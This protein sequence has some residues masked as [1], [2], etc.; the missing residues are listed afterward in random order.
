MSIY[1][2]QQNLFYMGWVVELSGDNRVLDELSKVLNLPELSIKKEDGSYYLESDIYNDNSAYKDVKNTVNCLLPKINASAKIV[3]NSHASIKLSGITNILENGKN[4]AY[5]SAT[6]ATVSCTAS[7]SI[8]VT[9]KDG[10]EEIHNPADPVMN[11]IKL[12]L[13]DDPAIKKVF[14]LVNYDF[15]SWVGLYNI[16]EAIQESIDGSIPKKG[17][18]SEN[19]SGLFGRTAC[20]PEAVGVKARHSNKKRYP[21][22]KNPMTH[23]EAKSFVKDLLTKWRKEKVDI[24]RRN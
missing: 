12:G 6:S 15:D 2:L 8:K 23:D 22:P 5:V 19:K 10:T 16:C 4:E 7:V 14:D 13:T 1:I 24:L 3:L 21:A 9:Y 20:S 18:C 11:W 17:W